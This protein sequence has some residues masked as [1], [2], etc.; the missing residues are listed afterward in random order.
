MNN[1][2]FD[3]G[4]MESSETV[5]SQLGP[6]QRILEAAYQ[7]FA[8]AGRKG[9]RTREIARRARV[10]IAMIHY[11]FSSKEELYM[12]V[13]TPIFQDIFS[14][15]RKAASLSDDPRERLQ[16]VV[17]VYFDFLEK[18][19]DFPRLMMWELASGGEAIQ[20]IFSGALT[21]AGAAFPDEITNIFK[22][23]QTKG[24]FR[25]HSPQHAVISMAALCVFPFITRKALDV[26]FPDLTG[27]P[28]FLSE[29]RQ[30]VLD[31][32]INGL[33]SHIK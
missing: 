17:N 23:G 9:A 21:E 7:V 10:N 3:A 16:A 13:V 29:R 20:R 18:H 8:E 25:R 4:G 5:P 31:L 19:P 6:R 30:Q 28:D 22:D 27:K 24:V 32:L 33:S 2:L 11:Y 14:R 26:M 1:T 12:R 15:L